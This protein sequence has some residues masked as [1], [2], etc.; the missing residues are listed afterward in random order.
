[1]ATS[2]LYDC[3]TNRRL[4]SKVDADRA[5]LVRISGMNSLQQRILERFKRRGLKVLIVTLA[6]AGLVVTVLPQK[7]DS[8][9]PEKPVKLVVGFAAGGGADAYA[10]ILSKLMYDQI[11]MPIAVINKTGAAR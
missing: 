10:R 4:R 11:G 8:G 3:C 7:K 1:M 5:N 2:Y 9:W 6:V